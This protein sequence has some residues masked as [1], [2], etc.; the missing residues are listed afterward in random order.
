MAVFIDRSRWKSFLSDFTKRNQSRPTHLEV[1]GDI[2]AQVEES[3]MP[4]LGVDVDKKGEATSVEIALG[5][6]HGARHLTHFVD[7]VERIAPIIG[8]NGLEDGL[9]I[10]GRNGVKTLLCFESLPEIEDGS[11]HSRKTNLNV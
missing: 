2:G 8:I 4:F 7:N 10:E 5:D 1:I 6:Q 11:S 9:G 3:H